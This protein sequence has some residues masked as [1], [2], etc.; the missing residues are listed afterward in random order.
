MTPSRFATL[1]SFERVAE[2]VVHRLRPVLRE[3]DLQRL[4]VGI[5][6]LVEPLRPE[7]RDQVNAEDALLRVDRARLLPVRLRVLD[8]LLPELRERRNARDVRRFLPA[9][10]VPGYAWA[11]RPSRDR[12]I[13]S[14]SLAS[15]GLIKPT[16]AGT[17][18]ALVNL[19]GPLSRCAAPAPK[20][21][22]LHADPRRVELLRAAHVEV[23]SLA[24]NHAL[25][26]GPEG[27]VESVRVLRDDRASPPRVWRRVGPSHWW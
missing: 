15:V 24:N 25:D 11:S 26:C 10:P 19:E 20:R 16:L 18:L 21:Y 9:E 14:A 1:R 17:D 12:V 5:G 23:V 22:P 2:D 8:E 4:H 27:L 6:D 3:R 7:D 13:T